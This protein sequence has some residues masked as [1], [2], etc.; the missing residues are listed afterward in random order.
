[1][2]LL[3]EAWLPFQSTYKIIDAE[4]IVRADLC[5]SMLHHLVVIRVSMHKE[6]GHT[7]DEWCYK[8]WSWVQV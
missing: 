3:Y 5:I 4:R 1:M 2:I 7:Q 6:L 8:Y